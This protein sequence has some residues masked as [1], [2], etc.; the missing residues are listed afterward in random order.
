MLVSLHVRFLDRFVVGTWHDYLGN[1]FFSTPRA[2]RNLMSESNIYLTELDDYG[3][4]YTSMFFF[5]PAV[6]VVIGSWTSLLSPWTAYG[7]FVAVSLGLL[8]VSAGVLARQFDSRTLQAFTFFALFCS[9]P[10]Y[11]MLW[12]AQMHVFVVVAVS[13]ILA[14]IVGIKR[15]E[16]VSRRSLRWLQAGLLIGLL[17]KPVVLLTLPVLFA[18]RETRRALVVPVA[19]YTAVSL[20]F[21][22][23]PTLNSGGYNGIH[24]LNL[25]N[26]AAA[27]S[28][29]YSLVYPRE[30]DYS[31]CPELYC[32]PMLLQRLTGAAPQQWLMKVP[33]FVVLAASALPLLLTS[34][35]RRIDVLL[36]TVLLSLLTH[37]LCFQIVWEYHYTTLL[38]A[39]PV[40]WWAGEREEQP[41]RRLWLRIAFFALLTIFLPTPYFLDFKE[42]LRL[43]TAGMLLRVV[44]VVV[45]F[46][47]LLSYVCGQAWTALAERSIGLPRSELAS[48][49]GNG[50]VLGVC[51]AALLAGVMFSVPERLLKPLVAWTDSDWQLQC[52][53]ILSRPRP[54]L[55]ATQIADLHFRLAR[56]YNASQPKLATE[57]FTTALGFVPNEPELLCE[58]GDRI[59]LCE[60]FEL[61]AT[62][63]QRVLELEPGHPYANMR[64]KQLR[65]ALKN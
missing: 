58:Y 32:L 42:H 33:V 52:E 12:N 65:A 28:P 64:V 15:D 55:S 20:L 34:L 27:A 62:V 24:W 5:H 23:G 63:F 18:T 19:V 7:A 26:G 17:T 38:P 49:L 50:G 6:A 11:L 44:P 30:L 14:A 43:T 21:L 4:R 22:F 56:A 13:L 31:T 45:S 40:L 9:L 1:D 61:A 3:P 60:H 51:N 54:G 36:V 47:C 53:D 10:T 57:H 37:F 8:A 35:R 59:L 48:L 16:Q 29:L 39:L 2:F 46:V 25:F 41:G